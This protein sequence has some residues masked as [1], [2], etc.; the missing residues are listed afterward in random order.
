MIS[1]RTLA[2]V[3]EEIKEAVH[4][5]SLKIVPDGTDLPVNEFGSEVRNENDGK[6]INLLCIL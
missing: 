3:Y 5:R 1:A 6:C 2:P 4:S